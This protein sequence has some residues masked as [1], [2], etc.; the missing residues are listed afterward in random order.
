MAT[1]APAPA[2]AGKT[3]GQTGGGGAGAGPGGLPTI[4]QGGKTAGTT[5]NNPAATL[6]PGAKKDGAKE[7]S[8]D[9]PDSSSV[10]RSD[11]A[12]DDKFVF[13]SSSSVKDLYRKSGIIRIKNTYNTLRRYTI[14]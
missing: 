2:A 13:S 3:A 8:L 5:A 4:P 14:D 1:S 7:G 12:S 9:R 10:V 11:S 6:P